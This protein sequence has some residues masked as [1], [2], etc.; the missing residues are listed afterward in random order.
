M[1]SLWSQNLYLDALSFATRAHQGQT[2]PGSDAPYV[3]HPV[4][5]AMELMTAIA[6][7][8][9]AAPDLAVQCALLH[10]RP[11]VAP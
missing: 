9:V 2:L 5:V 8:P 10:D 6:A 7:E 11:C 1:T 4:S 3:V